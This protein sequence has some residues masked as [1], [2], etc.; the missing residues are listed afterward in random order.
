MTTQKPMD[1]SEL[2]ARLGELSSEIRKT[3]EK[4][5]VLDSNYDVEGLELER[6]A[7]AELQ[8]FG[9]DSPAMRKISTE[10]KKNI[11]K[12]SNYRQSAASKLMLMYLALDSANLSAAS[13]I[14]GSFTNIPLSTSAD[15]DA[16]SIIR[17]F[18]N[19]LTESQAKNLYIGLRAAILA[20]EA[21]TAQKLVNGFILDRQEILALFVNGA[22]HFSLTNV[23]NAVVDTFIDDQNHQLL[24]LLVDAV[25]IAAGLPPTT[26]AVVT[27][28]ITFLFDVT[29][30]IR[31]LPEQ[32]TVPDPVKRVLETSSAL[33]LQENACHDTLLLVQKVTDALIAAA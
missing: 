19:D 20:E 13:K 26:V 23:V 1:L 27:H 2:L 6:K 28:S 16:R 25:G 12:F 9:L 29:M 8:K 21:L 14:L 30:K 7:I 17:N 4:Y 31:Q 22:E 33:T 24:C 3:K 11:V 15:P 32:Y 5:L 10:S 18:A